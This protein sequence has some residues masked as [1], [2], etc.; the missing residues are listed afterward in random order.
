MVI[1]NRFLLNT[2]FKT[3]TDGVISL[4]ITFHKHWITHHIILQ[5][6]VWKGQSRTQLFFKEEMGKG[7]HGKRHTC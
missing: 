3:N 5:A 2:F 7:K 4:H 6:E 1:Y